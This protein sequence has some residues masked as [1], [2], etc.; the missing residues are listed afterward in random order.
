MD[1]YR[2]TQYC[3]S[4]DGIQERKKIVKQLILKE[5]PRAK[6]MHTFI[7]NNETKYKSVFMEAYNNKCAYC[8]ASSD[9]VSKTSFEIDH[10]IYQKSDRFATKKDAGFMENLVLACHDCNNRK[11]EFCVEKMDENDLNPDEPGI[12]LNF[13]RN[14]M[15]YIV[16]T[17]KAINKPRVISFY[18]KLHLGSEMHR[19]DYLVLSM[20]GLKDTLKNKGIKCFELSEA[21]NI[22]ITKRNVM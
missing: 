9:F 4:L 16:P 12:M 14:D 15:F 11:K 21:I 3:K 7:S 20:I 18:E 10:F 8:G 6:D 2:R 22:L 17:G 19:I 1:D 13:Q 5:H